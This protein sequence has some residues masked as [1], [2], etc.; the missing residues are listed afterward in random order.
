[1][2]TVSSF[3]VSTVS[4]LYYW[5]SSLQYLSSS[6]LY[7]SVPNYSG[8]TVAF[9]VHTVLYCTVL[10]CTVHTGQQSPTR[11]RPSAGQFLPRYQLF[12]YL[13]VYPTSRP[14]WT[15]QQHETFTWL[16]VAGE[17]CSCI[18]VFASRNISVF[19]CIPIRHLKLNIPN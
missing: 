11:Y 3:T 19:V 4:Q 5:C 16:Q 7:S 1:M 12:N 9:T 8:L 17:F 14:G 6:L 13:F 2:S 18:C 15:S 10:F